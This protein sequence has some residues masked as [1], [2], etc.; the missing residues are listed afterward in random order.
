MYIFFY[1]YIYIY[2]TRSLG[3][4]LLIPH[5]FGLRKA[6]VLMLGLAALPLL[7][8]LQ[9]CEDQLDMVR[10]IVCMFFQIL[11]RTTPHHI[12]AQLGSEILL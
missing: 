5:A 4:R 3:R 11:V 1:I 7:G 6:H 10:H 9:N 12:A 2:A 8:V